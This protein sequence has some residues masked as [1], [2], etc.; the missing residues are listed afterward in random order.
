[1]LS[2]L[3]P[4]RVLLCVC[5]VLFARTAAAQPM[6]PPPAAPL[7]AQPAEATQPPAPPTAPVAEPPPTALAPAPAPF[8]ASSD[9]PSTQ[10]NLHGL[11]FSGGFTTGSGFSYRRYFGDTAAQ[12]NGIAI[13]SDYGNDALVFG[14]L[15]VIQYLM[16]WHQASSRGLLPS[17]TALRLVGGATYFYSRQTNLNSVPDPSCGINEFC[18]WIDQ[19]TVSTDKLFGLGAGIGFEFGAIMHPGFSVNLDL[20]LTAAFD[21]AGLSFILPL[22]TAGLMYSW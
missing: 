3:R 19:E 20:M 6:E 4:S 1:M 16:I 11:G 17:V 10:S 5:A 2:T 14:G 21:E 12:L 13:V 18:T 8:P 7:P 15:S 22:P 9:G